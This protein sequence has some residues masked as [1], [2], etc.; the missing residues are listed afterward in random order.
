MKQYVALNHLRL[1]GKGWEIRHQLRK[2]SASS[3]SKTPMSEYTERYQRAPCSFR[4]NKLNPSYKAKRQ[5][6]SIRVQPKLSR[7]IEGLSVMFGK[8]MQLSNRRKYFSFNYSA[9][10]CLFN[11]FYDKLGRFD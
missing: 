6:P 7:R 8:L 4:K 11:D 3:L 10:C 2:L 5:K 1:V 9:C